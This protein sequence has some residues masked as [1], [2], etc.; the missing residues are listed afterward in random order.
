MEDLQTDLLIKETN[1]RSKKL[2]REPFKR[3]WSLFLCSVGT[4]VVTLP[5]V[6]LVWW[7]MKDPD[8]L[9]PPNPEVPLPPSPSLLEEFYNSAVCTDGPPCSKIGSDLLAMGGS[10]VD[11]AIGALFC[12]GLVNSQSMGLGG[13]FI[14]TLYM[15]GKPYSLIA[16]ETAPA[17]ANLRMFSGDQQQSRTGGLAIGVPGELR[18]YYE[19]WKRFGKLE[20]AKLVEPT[21]K[22][23][24]EGY[25]LSQPQYESLLFRPAI[26]DDP[27]FS[28]MFV[29]PET[30]QFYRRG[31]VIKPKKIC[32]TLRTIMIE[33][34][35]AIH[36]GSLTTLIA[37]DIEALGGLVTKEDLNNY[38]ADWM[39]PV[40]ITLK[41]GERVY[42][43]PPPGSG[44]LV[45]YILSIL[46]G[47]N[48]SKPANLDEEILTVHRMLEAFKFAF[49]RRTELADPKFVN[50]SQLVHNLTSS[51][52]AMK[53][54]L[55]IN[56]T[57]T[58]N[59]PNYYGAVFYNQEDHGTAHISVLSKDGDAV[60]VTSTINLYFGAGATSPGTGIILNSV[61]DDFSIPGVVNYFQL[62]PSPN[63]FIEPGKRPL[64]SACP[65]IVVGADGE[66]KL[67]VGASGGTKIT[68]VVAWV[69]MRHLWFGED[70]K[71]AVDASRI[72]HQLAPMEVS[73]EYGVLE[74]VV[75]GLKKLGH[76]TNRYNDR[77]SV[78]CAIAK[79]GSIIFGNADFRK[80][81]AVFGL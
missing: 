70:V 3:Q 15:K 9:F 27:V 77:G 38:K 4:I 25:I 72:H 21:V 37:E 58:Y 75:A 46:D 67:V 68:T 44:P 65:T 2:H 34:G 6:I 17:A 51:Q 69:I 64:S 16:R 28:Q 35:N 13:G 31:T 55:R 54:R 23:C 19:A 52:Y 39:D 78:V 12:N 56:D 74:Q 73:Y 41:G 36:N 60:S 11:A 10:A 71:Q 79:N 26:A 5:L 14:M 18:G 50:I 43:A 7:L 81:G 20:W 22:L 63:N 1:S 45:T 80:G 48:M 8:E 59:E 33:G 61:M 66:V 40:S 47:Y 24:G 42:S 32:D 30:K 62:P 76:K 29:D 49:A 57:R 53:T